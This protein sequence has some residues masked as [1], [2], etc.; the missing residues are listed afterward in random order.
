M[1][2]AEQPALGQSIKIVCTL[3]SL[4]QE[5]LATRSGVRAN[6][7]SMVERGDRLLSGPELEAFAVALKLSVSELTLLGTNGILGDAGD[8]QKSMQSLIIESIMCEIEIESSSGS[9]N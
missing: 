9:V 7:V 4:T 5:E 3:W 1:K 6:Y 2:M 8:L